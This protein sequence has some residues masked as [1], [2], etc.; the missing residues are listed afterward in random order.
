MRTLEIDL[1]TVRLTA[2]AWGPDDGPLAVL[3]HGFPDSALTWRHLGP[4]LAR[5]GYRVLAPFTR[6]YAPS[7]IPADR[8]YQVAALADDAVALHREA[9]GGPDAV[10]IGHD[11]GAITANTLAAH[12][13]SPFARV[14]SM[15]V[16]PFSAID[17][18]RSVR[19]LPGQLLKSRYIAFHQLPVLPERTLARR[20]PAL[21]RAWS[22]GYDPAED[23]PAALAAVRDPEHARAAIGY[24]RALTRPWGVPER[25]RRWA[26][27]TW[28]P[29]R[30]P[31]LYLH[32]R[33]DGCMDVR[34]AAPLVGAPQRLGP[35]GGVAIIDGAGHFL[36]LEQP[37]AVAERVLAFLAD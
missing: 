9:G 5:A 12:P 24:Y 16:P 1:P 29:P 15:A 6:G 10:L 37:A 25:Y 20:I 33:E 26:S 18:R 11:W 22:P 36:H 31:L 34:L 2:L 8:C 32:G 35:A 30:S 7:A 28:A 17:S 27:A 21:W 3:L 19:A 14:V 4:E 23:L 13:D